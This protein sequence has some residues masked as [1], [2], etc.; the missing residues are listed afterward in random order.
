M[1]T[2]CTYIGKSRT[3]KEDDF[4]LISH[5]IIESEEEASGRCSGPTAN[6]SFFNV[7][8]VIADFCSV[9]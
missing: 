4:E 3:Y 1:V 6:L 7:F 9:G 5:N 8:K 2:N